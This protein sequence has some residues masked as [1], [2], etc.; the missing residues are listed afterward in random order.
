MCSSSTSEPSHTPERTAGAAVEEEL[1]AAVW[2]AL[3]QR[4]R[5]E[6]EKARWG[7]GA[8][9][10]GARAVPLCFPRLLIAQRAEKPR[11]RV[12]D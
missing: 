3:A 10:K 12:W 5:K 1:I 11:G 6:G 7:G 8:G 9:K 2:C 4:R